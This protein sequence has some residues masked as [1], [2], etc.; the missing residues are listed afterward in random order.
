LASKKGGFQGKVF[1]NKNRKE[2]RRENTGV[3][4][5]KRGGETVPEGEVAICKHVYGGHKNCTPT[6]GIVARKSG[7]GTKSSLGETG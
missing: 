2:A 1:E 3:R 7:A 4:V 5:D 6:M